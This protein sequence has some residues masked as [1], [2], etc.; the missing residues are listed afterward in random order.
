MTFKYGPTFFSR[1]EYLFSLLI[2]KVVHECVL[3]L[4]M[5]NAEHTNVKHWT[6]QGVEMCQQ[7]GGIGNYGTLGEYE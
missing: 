7:S 6:H 1:V 2:R 5:S 4:K 3:D